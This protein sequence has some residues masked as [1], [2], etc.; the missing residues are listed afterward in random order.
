M[1]EKK[2]TSL[3]LEIAGL[4]IEVL[5]EDIFQT[6]IRKASHVLHEHAIHEIYYMEEG[7]MAFAC[8]GNYT[9]TKGDLFV[10]SAGSSHRVVRYSDDMRWFHFRFRIIPESL[11]HEIETHYFPFYK[12]EVMEKLI[13]DIRSYQTET[14][15]VMARYR[16]RSRIGILLSFILE[17]LGS[18]KGENYLRSS[19]GKLQKSKLIRYSQIDNFLYDN[20]AGD[21]RLEDLAR[22]LH[23]SC[24]QT[25]RL[26]RECCGMSF[27]EKL[28]EIR[29]RLA[30]ELLSA[31]EMP[32]S[33]VAERCGYQT[34]QGFE[35]AFTH[36]VGVSPSAFRKQKK[37]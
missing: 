24:V 9:L 13:E 6:E 4:T 7:E 1:T 11:G 14:D 22:H 34:R 30:K 21:I 20:C 32:I 29:I 35:A 36:M 15:S 25:A 12:H 33:D 18:K 17:S 2:P 16:F 31:G 5:T 28:R 26:V 23:Y 10:I 37:L 27:T 8:N 3:Q 19:K